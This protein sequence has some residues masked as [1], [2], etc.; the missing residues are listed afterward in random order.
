M[1]ITFLIL[2]IAFAFQMAYTQQKPQTMT[3]YNYE[4]AWQEA[5]DFENKGLPESAL[6]V[7]NTIYE[8]AKKE[9]NAGQL[10]KAVVHQLKFTDYKE[11]NAFVKN[12]NKLREE[13]QSS[14]FPVK[15][16]LH[17]MLAEMY[18][19]Y[20]Q[21]NRYRFNERS[22]VTNVQ[23]DDIE[24]WSLNK[25]VDE[26]FDQ[27]KL[28]LQESEK[29]KATSI[30]L[31][32]PIL[33]PGNKLGRSYRATLYDF[34][35]HRA[36]DFSSGEEASI[37]RP[38]Y[39]FVLDKEEYLSPATSFA[40]LPITTKDTLSM[41]FYALS[42][43]QQLI[44]FHLN[45][46]DPEA[47]VDVD[48]KRLTFVKLNLIHANKNEA[49]RK[50]L[51]QLEQQFISHPISTRVTHLLAQTYME[52]GSQYSPLK[53][54][55]HK[56]DFKKAFEICET[57]KK[58]FPDSDGAI[59]CENLQEDI[60]TKSISAS[61]EE[62]NLPGENF[63]SIVRY[64]NFTDLHYRIIKTN[65][66]EI[67]SQRKKWDRN[68]NVD[69][70]QKF[71]EYFV[72][73]TPVKSGKFVLPDDKDYQQ[74]SIEVKLDALP[75]G[76]YM[77]L[78]SHRPDFIT[79]T[80]GLAYAFTSIT[81]ISY[82]HR[83]VKDGTT[84]FYTLNRQSGEPLA[85]VLADVYSNQYNYKK[86]NYELIKIGSF[87]S[88]AKGYFKVPYV[89]NDNHRSFSVSFRL[90]DDRFSTEPIDRYEYYGGTI[91][92]YKSG[93]PQKHLQTFFFLDRAIYRPGQTI[94]FKGLVVNTD[95]KTS[96]LQAKFSTSITLYDVNHQERGEVSVT[97]NEYGTFSGTF[98]APSTGLTGQMSLEDNYGNGSVYFSVEEYKRPKF[99]VS[100]EPV[101]GSFRLEE[102]IQAE[103]LARAYSGANIDGALVSYRV[104]RA[105]RF[106]FWWWC[107][108]GNYP[109]SAEMEITN[110]VTQTDAQGKFK[111][112]FQAIPDRSV[113][114]TS[115]PIFDY[116]VYADVT[117]INGETHS[118]STFISVGYKA[119]QVSASIGNINKDQITATSKEI[120]ISTTNLAGLFEAAKGKVTI[121]ELKSLERT[122]RSRQ[123]EQ[124]D[125]TLYTRGQYYQYFPNDLYEDE[126]NKFKWERSKEIFNLNFDTNLKKTFTLDDLSQWKVGEYVLE[127]SALDASGQEVKE[128]TYF[129]VYAPAGKSIPT[130][131]VHYFQPVKLT[132]EPGEKASF[133]TGTT[134]RKIRVLYQIERDGSLLFSEWIVLNNEQRLF[135]IPIREEH[136]G[137]LGI[138]YTFIK[139]NRLYKQS[140][141]ISVP[142]SNKTLN[143]SFE[144]FRDKLQP[145]Q[146]EQW[147]IL[148]KGKSAEKVAAEMVATLYDE[149][150]DEFRSNSWYAN[151]FGSHYSQLG[152]N[153]TNGFNPKS[154]TPYDRSWNPGH[155]R[156]PHGAYFD[157]FNWFDY[158][159]Y[160]YYY[161]NR[162]FRAGAARSEM[163]KKA[164]ESELSEV[165]MANSAPAP[166]VAQEADDAS[167]LKGDVAYKTDKS[168]PE[169]KKEDFSQVKVR[170]NFNETAFF[171]PHL[172]TNADG[173][174]IIN[175]T[176]PE[177]LTRWKM[178]GFAHTTDLKSGSI[179]NH[180]VT[181]K[182]LMVVPNQPRFF[183]ENDKMIFQ[184]KVSSLV[185][186]ELSGQ[187]QL[188]FFD[189]LTMKPVDD[190]MKNV[191][192]T[193]SFS[194][195]SR[196]SANLE[197]SIEIPEGLQAIT[198]RV[199]AK[200]GNFSDGEEMTIP[201]VTNRM[202]VTESLPLP[203]RGKQT[204]EFKFEKLLNTKSKTLRHHRFTLEFTSNPAWYAIQALPYL[205]EY[206][207][208][209]VE[210]TFSKFYANSIASHIANSNPRIKQVFDTWKNIQPD[211]LLSNLEKNQELKSALLEETPWVLHAKDESQRKRNVGLLFDLNR[212]ANEQERALD[213]IVKAQNSSGG[214][215]WFPGFPEDRYMTQHIISGIGHLDVLGVKSV[216]TEA[217][218]WNMVNSAIGYLD[219]QVKDDYDRLKALAKRG[220]IKLEDKHIG[221][222]QIH[223]LYTRSY[224]K[225]ITVPENVNEAFQYYL[226]QA[227][228][229][230]L[231]K[232]LYLEGMTSLALHRFGDKIT[233]TAMIK[234][235]NERALRSEEMGM[236]WKND[237]GYYWYQAPIETQALMIEVYDEVAS[238][239]KS[240][241]ELK[242]W[243]LKQKQAQD[244]KTT[245][246][247]TEACYALLRR[248]TD[249]LANSKLVDIKVGN[250]TIDP[251]KRENTKVE[252]GTGYFK[253]AWQANE[254]NSGMGKITVSKSDEGVAWGAAYW[255]YFE[256]LDKIT[257]AE[258]PLKLTKQLFK[259]Q[260][261]DRGPVITPITEKSP[262]QIGD[263]VKVRIELR[264]DREMEYVHL[265]DMRAAG[266]E[267]VSTLSTYRYQDGL[268]YYEST[269]DLATNFFIG[270][271]SK[272]TYVFEYDL[273]VSQKGDFS[274]GVTNIQCMYAPE[275]ASHSEGIRINVK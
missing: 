155:A 56:W 263:L 265:K 261:T 53:S 76:E 128:V 117:D 250:E 60:L 228:K 69:R 152:W 36:L 45:D 200:A 43:L 102:T 273:R 178:L 92:Q 202:L 147:K 254:I 107:R 83:S 240:V 138:H 211:A 214:F 26:T 259:Q 242:V 134:D 164:E 49:Y 91:S 126:T 210:Q 185:D 151:F 34:L 3:P 111:I 35:A 249:V 187:A 7:V 20:Y 105:A 75:P 55:D 256:Q 118:N 189:A 233:P 146:Q 221:Y 268:Y 244:W 215:S 232:N 59:E 205:M 219:R 86:Q 181:Q 19:Q 193:K 32:E 40:K 148:I 42:L 274:N 78:F 150:L 58:R 247:T 22:E 208:D 64:K 174:I 266:L 68:Y 183:R 271:L 167:F 100:F 110:G 97:T 127:I 82:I 145:G 103:G 28:S 248:G 131:Q 9:Q 106:P 275:F 54:D 172:Q 171:Y 74:H 258:T 142:Y 225:D 130:P 70:E 90:G 2:S 23:Q 85:K 203:I 184:V 123:W 101:K 253:T 25:I 157:T 44:Q 241:E 94:Y 262:L 8:Q 238:D 13:A 15:P 4:K 198:Y 179:I 140:S 173:E 136:R 124:A 73:K 251:A 21:N 223:Y 269:R 27:Y 41:R 33:Y 190:V 61:I 98:I 158:S 135:E 125:R 84:E 245:K 30:A 175:F 5:K 112:A 159:F 67:S 120:S 213:K 17:S 93:E 199:V 160:Q 154:L 99:E 186:A 38:V 62:T 201:V 47:L 29:S 234:S 252:A 144:S 18:W 231:V 88:D 161:G 31:Y 192:K 109:T 14:A 177:A 220:E 224:F 246:A 180:L 71:I 272:G 270:Y 89:K 255:Q 176:I 260:N 66:E 235:F 207:Y 80:N 65:R 52:Q 48:I 108:W 16:V 72:S 39:A 119:L 24:T 212:M 196:Q 191:G 236:Y 11:E 243:L 129:T 133:A 206:P 46:K 139:N 63:R 227:K 195:K 237:Y 37:T 10:V 226:G 87:V 149:S 222:V 143:V 209:C 217:R 81:N 165:V 204:K 96:D 229:Y 166:A 57:A 264:V 197:W 116:T 230:W 267:P 137:D 170:T 12:L 169:V 104:V 257:P 239:L 162:R 95:G 121:Y 79:T 122:F 163:N 50:A 141:T 114:R 77:V 188:E 6:K 51:E 168:K 182:D 113:D 216:R 156:S 115:D 194:L 218:T 153:S 132:A 1:K